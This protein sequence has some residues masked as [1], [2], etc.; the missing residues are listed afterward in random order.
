[1]I[2]AIAIVTAGLFGTAAVAVAVFFGLRRLLAEETAARYSS[3]AALAAAFC[4]GYALPIASAPWVPKRHWHWFPWLVLLAA[5]IGPISLA[6][7]LRRA[8][9]WL[10]NLGVAFVAA[11]VLVPLWSHL[12]PARSVWIPLLA[13]Y[14]FLLAI[15][16][17]PLLDRF[18]TV[19]LPAYLTM[20]AACLALLLAALLSIVYGQVAGIAVAALAGRTAAAYFERGPTSLRGLGLAYAVLFG[21]W[22]FVG[23]VEQQEPLHLLLLLVPAAPLALWCC[24]YGPLSRL[25]GFAAV[26]IQTALVILVLVIVAAL[27]ARERG[28]SDEADEYGT[29]QKTVDVVTAALAGK[30]HQ[31]APS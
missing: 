17:E 4:A 29:I 31:N 13:G 3:A 8:E 16:L 5:A 9:R 19:M 27:L 1:M 11:W 30:N 21:G 10:L 23:C 6:S 2:S 20:S 28:E 18:S 26:G 14:L 7:G 12:H 25:R 22:A 24:V 15:L